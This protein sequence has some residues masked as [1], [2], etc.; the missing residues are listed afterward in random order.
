VKEVKASR[1][2]VDSPALLTSADGSPGNLQKVMKALHRDFQ[3]TP[4]VLEINPAHPLIRDM[5]TL[6]GRDPAHPA[7]PEL[8][9]QLY[10]NCL[11]VE[12]L[13]DRPEKMVTRIQSLM[14]RAAA[15]EAA[16]GGEGA[17]R[18]GERD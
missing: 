3:S 1:R 12:G 10:A 13:I 4:K 6:R 11:L 7:L 2:L 5:A 16:Q 18:A 17:E 14:A 15:L 9:E 8:A